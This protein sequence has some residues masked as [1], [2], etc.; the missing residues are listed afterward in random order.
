MYERH[1][2]C[3]S[4]LLAERPDGLHNVEAPAHK[5][6][7]H[8]AGPWTMNSHETYLTDGFLWLMATFAGI[9]LIGLI[10]SAAYL[11]DRA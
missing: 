2:T 4:A 10:M 7:N 8:W 3:W 9:M 6:A 5:V 1:A 11:I